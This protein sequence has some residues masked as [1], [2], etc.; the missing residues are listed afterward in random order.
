M[1]KM[2]KCHFLMRAMLLACRQPSSGYVL[3]WLFLSAHMQERA[4]SLVSL[5]IKALIRSAQGPILATLLSLIASLE[6][7]PQIQSS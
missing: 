5:L 2:P 6:P 4:C 7:H 1:I 3:T